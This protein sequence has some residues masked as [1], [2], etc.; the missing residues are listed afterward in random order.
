MNE[1]VQRVGTPAPMAAGNGPTADDL[2]GRLRR[3]VEAAHP[4][5]Y[6]GVCEA[7]AIDERRFDA[8]VGRFLQWAVKARGVGWIETMADAYVLFTTDVNLEQVRYEASG[9]YSHDDYAS[10]LAE[11]YSQRAV[12]DEYLWGVYLNNFL[13]AHH[14]RLACFYEDRFLRALPD[15]PLR[16]VDIAY[17]HGAWGLW[18]LAERPGATLEGY[19]ISTSAPLIAGELARAAGLASRA[20]YSTRNA[21]ELD[22]LPPGSADVCICCFLVEHLEDPA[23]LFKMIAHLLKP[24]GKAFVAGAL[25]AAQVDHIHEFRHESELLRLGEAA[26]LRSLETISLASER[27]LPHARFIPRSMAMIM[28]KDERLAKF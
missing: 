3:Y 8:V 16:I 13:W 28:E 12:M 25:T 18:A 27:Q 14:F 6:K 19:D 26:A 4:R 22:Q 24:R 23:R 5:Y 11:T 17:G 20:T 1:E 7:R 2:V 15:G 10:C 9:R 21:M